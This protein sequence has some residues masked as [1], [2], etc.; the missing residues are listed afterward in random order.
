MTSSE[1]ILFDLLEDSIAL[2]KEDGAHKNAAEFKSFMLAMLPE[3]VLFDLCE[4]AHSESEPEAFLDDLW[5]DRFSEPSVQ[6][7]HDTILPGCCLIC[8]RLSR[9]TRHHVFP[10]ST[11]SKMLNKRGVSAERLK[12]TISI[13]RMCHSTLH[14]FFTNEELAESYYTV[15]LLLADQKFYSYAK[16][17]SRQTGAS[18]GTR[19]VK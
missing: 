7:A 3:I 16:W 9:L 11:H 4:L 10:L 6:S 1:A 12:T 13:C 15:E 2:A 14:R 8:E 17:A 19:R 18:C 5:M